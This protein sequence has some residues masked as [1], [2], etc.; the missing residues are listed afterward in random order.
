MKIKINEKDIHSLKAQYFYGDKYKPY[1]IRKAIYLNINHYLY[2]NMVKGNRSLSS[3]LRKLIVENKMDLLTNAIAKN[4]KLFEYV[5][6]TPKTKTVKVSIGF[7]N[8]R[9]LNKLIKKQTLSEF[10][11]KKLDLIYESQLNFNKKVEKELH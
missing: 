3:L 11:N 1:K 7:K 10:A 2:L 4:T 5:Y 6:S 9:E 8:E